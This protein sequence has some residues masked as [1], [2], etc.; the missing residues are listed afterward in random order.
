MSP[1]RY[2]LNCKYKLTLTY[3]AFGCCLTVRYIMHGMKTVKY[4]YP[5]IIF[6]DVADK[7]LL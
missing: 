1:T 7:M 2:V 3:C 5:A 4:F 6:K